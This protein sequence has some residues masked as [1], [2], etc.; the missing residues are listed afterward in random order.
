MA[1]TGE[2]LGRL[3]PKAA[4]QAVDKLRLLQGKKA[5]REEQELFR[6]Q[7]QLVI[8]QE[9]GRIRELRVHPQFTLR[10]AYETPDGKRVP[11]I[12]HTAAFS[13]ERP[14]APDCTG[15]VHW[16]LTVE[17]MRGPGTKTREYDLR[18]RLLKERYGVEIRE[19]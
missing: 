7:R 19:V 8:L 10:D 15:E 16:L 6:R 9:R 18:R 11:A 1:L 14:T 17:D 12:R 5:G 3:S 13:Y 4:R 2:D